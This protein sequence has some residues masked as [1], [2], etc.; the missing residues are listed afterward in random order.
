KLAVQG[1]ILIAVGVG[2][3]FAIRHT[4]ASSASGVTRL[5]RGLRV[6]IAAAIDMGV[7]VSVISGVL[8]LGRRVLG[9]GLGAGWFDGAFALFIVALFYVLIARFGAGA[10]VGEA[11]LQTPY[12]SGRRLPLRPRA[13]LQVARDL[14]AGSADDLLPTAELFRALGDP[15]RLRVIRHLVDAGRTADQLAILTGVAA[16]EVLHSIQRFEAVGLLIVD[17]DGPEAT[18]RV[19]PTLLTPLLEFLALSHS[20]ADEAP[21]H[22]TEIDVIPTAAPALVVPGPGR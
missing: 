19:K 7:V 6:G 9:M 10:T 22:K 21:I 11:L 20:P 12:V 5:P 2:G 8:S 18:Y 16:V 3:Y 13:L 14:L 15:D 1:V 17:G 4:P